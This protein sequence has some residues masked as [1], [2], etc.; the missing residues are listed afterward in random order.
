MKSLLSVPEGIED[1]TMA[2][3]HFQEVFEARYGRC[4]PAFLQGSL[5][6]AIT[7]AC[8]QPARHVCTQIT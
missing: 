8:Q 2:A 1:E 7:Q 6:D 3:F 4:H 5:N